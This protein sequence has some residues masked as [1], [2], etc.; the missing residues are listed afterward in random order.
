M[1]ETRLQAMRIVM[2][3]ALIYLLVAILAL[4]IVREGFVS[5]PHGERGLG[6][7]RGFWATGLATG[8]VPCPG[9]AIVL[10]FS[11]A[12]GALWLGLAAV[13]A[14]A[15]GMGGTIAAAAG[16]AACCRGSFLS[17]SAS[18]PRLVAGVRRGLALVG[19]VAIFALG[20]TLFCGTF[21]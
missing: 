2:A 14:M 17:M 20:V 11:M 6:A 15:L 13:G 4:C 16:L 1:R 12:L 3:M 5:H 7:D 8:M 19:G 21:V 18:R 10:L 9:A